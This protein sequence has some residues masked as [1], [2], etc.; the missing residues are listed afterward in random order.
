[1][2]ANDPPEIHPWKANTRKGYLKTLIQYMKLTCTPQ[3]KELKGKP[4]N[5][6]TQEVLDYLED[7]SSNFKGSGYV[8]TL[9][10]LTKML[11]L[12]N[13]CSQAKIPVIISGESG[14][15]KTHLIDYLASV[16]LGDEF[17]CVTIDAG[18]SLKK[19]VQKMETY[20]ELARSFDSKKVRDNRDSIKKVWILLDEFNTS[21]L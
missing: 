19:F 15:G 17:K 14:M 21:S 6:T 7:A 8:L 4:A 3:N 20:I 13:A 1:M 12:Y 5:E 9:D 10:N 2:F 16:V 18:L 11:K